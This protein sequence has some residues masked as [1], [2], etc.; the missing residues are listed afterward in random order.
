MSFPGF[1]FDCFLKTSGVALDTNQEE[2]MIKHFIYAKR[3]GKCGVMGN[4][5]VKCYS[6]TPNPN[7]SPSSTKRSM[8]Q[9]DQRFIVEHD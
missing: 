2:K 6:Q 7:S 8:A 5:F 4:R 1:S 3:A 9:H